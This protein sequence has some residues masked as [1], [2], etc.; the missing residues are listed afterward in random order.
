MTL[1]SLQWYQLRL[2][3]KNA[4]KKIILTSLK[5]L[6]LWIFPEKLKKI[7]SIRIVNILLVPLMKFKGESFLWLRLRDFSAK[8]QN[9]FPQ[10]LL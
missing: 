2:T 3:R 6:F 7:T 1:L 5:K 9:N 8:L 4:F 10:N